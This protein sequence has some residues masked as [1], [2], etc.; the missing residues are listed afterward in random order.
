M[1]AGTPSPDVALQQAIVHH[2]AG[3][4]VEAERLYRAVLQVA[5]NRSDAHHNLGVLAMQ[6]GRADLG[7]SCFKAAWRMGPGRA[8]YW[9]SYA[10]ALLAVG[11][12]E[13]ALGLLQHSKQLGISG[14]HSPVA[15]IIRRISYPQRSTSRV[16][17]TL[18]C[19]LNSRRRWRRP[20]GRWG[21][22]LS[23]IADEVDGSWREQCRALGL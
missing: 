4:L 15:R 6:G 14:K 16:N 17:R 3:R 13:E 12:P 11:R 21:F 8:Q 18:R 7:L 20:C 2:Q 5:P 1:T 22:R 10:Q 9:Q 19:S 23:A